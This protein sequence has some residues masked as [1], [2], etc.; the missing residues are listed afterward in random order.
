MD[1]TFIVLLKYILKHELKKY[2]CL[3]LCPFKKIFTFL[4]F[5]Y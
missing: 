2:I 1:Y 3:L 4:C 5:N